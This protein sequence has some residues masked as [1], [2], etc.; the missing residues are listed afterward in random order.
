MYKPIAR[1][2]VVLRQRLMNRLNAGLHGKLTLVSAPAGFG[3]TTLIA[4]W[5]T[6]SERPTA[7]LSLDEGD[8]NPVRFLTYL[9]AA[10]QTVAPQIGTGIINLLES[11]QPPPMESLITSILNEIVAIPHEFVLV[12]DDYHI[13]DNQAIDAALTFLTENMP[14]QMHLI[15]TT[16][17]DPLLPLA[18]LRARGQLTELRA[19][20]LRFTPGES[21][22]FFTQSMGLS[23]SSS[24]IAA[25]EQRTEGWIAGLQLAAISMQGQSNTA[26]FIE[27]F[28]SNHQ[29]V[30]DYLVEEVLDRQPPVIQDFLLQTSILDRV[31][32]PLCDAILADESYT[33]ADM[34]ENIRK[35][36]LFLEP[37]DNERCWYRYH[38]LFGSLLRKRLHQSPHLNRDTLHRRASTWFEANG[39]QAEA[40][41]HAAAAND[42]ARAE[43]LIEGNGTPLYVLGTVVPVLRWFETLPRHV[44]DANPSLCVIYATVL[45][46]SGQ[47]ID[48]IEDLLQA[49]TNALEAQPT[50][51]KHQDLHGRIAAIRAMLAGPRQD[52][53][54]ML[55]QSNRALELLH[56][57]NTSMRGL[58]LWTKGLAHQH[59]G[60]L[61]AARAVYT[62][63]V[64]TS[65][66]S[67]NTMMLV[68]ALT[69]LGQLQEGNNQLNLAQQS[70]QRV[71][72]QVGDPP[73]TTA[74]EAYLGLGRVSYAWGEL[75][76]AEK[77]L[78]Q[79]LALG[80][81]IENVVTPIECCLLL[82]EIQIARGNLDG[83]KTSLV[84]CERLIEQRGFTHKLDDMRIVQ[85][86]L[87]TWQGKGH[88]SSAQPLIEPLSDR[89]LEVLRLVANGFSNREISKRLF[90]A[91]D[92]IKGH[93]R[94]IY[95]KLGVSR[96][97]EAVARARQ[98]GIL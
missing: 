12:L 5:I 10:L 53:E 16:R 76:Q 91:L 6:T 56:P 86:R 87:Q 13:L 90:L 80:L 49:A 45:T 20:D 63:I 2:G 1:P 95:A 30:L 8:S 19:A 60:E 51:A 23:L 36:N 40:F 26:D 39:S 94:R 17:E 88:T 48:S 27:S 72:E 65:Q 73:W 85:A 25:L 37:L 55:T 41:Q 70:Y 64:S 46:V 3:K 54:T 57:D 74:C 35:A 79:G 29:F 77:H 66:A 93:N 11:P 38:H 24:D 68:A 84:E 75:D 97:T 33:S 62:E 83:A 9:V 28:T 18:R 44:L 43:L 34:L 82:A 42:L 81:Q 59:R 21:T 69:C 15:I 96:R 92:T 58:V 50:N 14:P 98:L 52:I 89:E 22:E 71:L 31:C 7:W 32:G 61:D 47:Q 78:Q 67:G 4:E